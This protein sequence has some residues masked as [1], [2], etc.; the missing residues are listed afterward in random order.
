MPFILEPAILLRLSF[1]VHLVRF[2][3]MLERPCVGG[4]SLLLV[5]S[6]GVV[7]GDC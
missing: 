3:V 2:W 1:A 4:F 7:Y 5:A 6:Y